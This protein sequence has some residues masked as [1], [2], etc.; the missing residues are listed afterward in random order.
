MAQAI[1]ATKTNS[2]NS[3]KTRTLP[4]EAGQTFLAGVPVMID[5]ADGG[6]KEWTGNVADL[7]AGISAGDGSNLATTGL[8]APGAMLP[9]LGL[10]ATLTYPQAVPNQ[11]NAKIIPIGAP[12]ND[13]RIPFYAA[14]QDTVFE[15]QVGPAQTTVAQ[16]VGVA[17]GLTKDADNHWYIDRTKTG[18]N[19]VLVVQ[20]LHP[21]DGPKLA[22]R[23]LFMFKAANSAVAG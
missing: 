14:S 20:M 15:G 4:E 21:L 1:I 13:G 23:V 8:N 17:Y 16:D 7:I 9:Y 12:F 5:G 3:A 6:I 10:G 19:A 11:P 18:A 22:G 2:G